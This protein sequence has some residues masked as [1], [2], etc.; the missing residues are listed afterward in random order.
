[1]PLP[2]SPP[3]D[4]LRTTV[5]PLIPDNGTSASGEVVALGQG[6]FNQVCVCTHARACVYA[7]ARVCVCRC[8]HVCVCAC[9]LLV[10]ARPVHGHPV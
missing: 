9:S 4:L 10:P 3:P 5:P 7:G 8:V 2:P 1:M 6:L